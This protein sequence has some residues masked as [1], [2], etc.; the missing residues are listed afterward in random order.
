MPLFDKIYKKVRK[1]GDRAAQYARV[2]FYVDLLFCVVILPLSLML[3]PVDR[4]FVNQPSF[5]LVFLVYTYLLY[6]VY[7]KV[8]IPIRIHPADGGAVAGSD[9]TV[10][11]FPAP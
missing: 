8:N 2:A 4:W 9:G 3:V 7:R 6:F 10:D 11:P 5:A 1:T